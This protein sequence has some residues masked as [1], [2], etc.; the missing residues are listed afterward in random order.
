MANSAA[1]WVRAMR[2]AGCDDKFIVG[3]LTMFLNHANKTM[4]K[5]GETIYQLRCEN[6]LLRARVREAQAIGVN[7]QRPEPG[8]DESM[9]G[10]GPGQ[11][12]A[13][14]GKQEPSTIPGLV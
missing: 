8:E 1:A 6:E 3:Q 2:E 14:I 13:L 11:W 5:Q 7:S 10:P 12:G 4:G 9:W